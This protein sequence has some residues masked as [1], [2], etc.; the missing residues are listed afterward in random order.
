[1]LS[2]YV[3]NALHCLEMNLIEKQ[4]CKL[5]I[6]KII[7]ELP[8]KITGRQTVEELDPDTAK[9]ICLGATPSTPTTGSPT[10]GF[11]E[12]AEYCGTVLAYGA[13]K[14]RYSTLVDAANSAAI[15]TSDDYMLSLNQ[16]AKARVSTKNE[17]DSTIG[18][19]KNISGS[20]PLLME[21]AR[22]T[23]WI[24]PETFEKQKAS[25][26]RD[27]LGL[28]QVP[29]DAQ[30]SSRRLV[31][32]LFKS[33]SMP[34]HATMRRP[35]VFDQPSPRFRALTRQERS[36]SGQLVHGKTA[37][38]GTYEDGYPELVATFGKDLAAEAQDWKIEDLGSIR[39]KHPNA[40]QHKE[41]ADD[42]I[43]GMT[44]DCSY[45]TL[46]SFNLEKALAALFSTD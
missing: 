13:L 42:L 41:F 22:T 8:S 46:R 29:R 18:N 28:D 39:S 7:E 27:K 11:E 34:R 14:A 45:P 4:D 25:K 31:R 19:I 26:F 32:L 23:L 24:A 10:Q 3:T 1:M 44:Q 20:V 6:G 2:I 35:T 16:A 12:L 37:H 5:Y 21:N 40:D 36:S 30:P 43:S 38:L 15:E 33:K 9:R 17:I